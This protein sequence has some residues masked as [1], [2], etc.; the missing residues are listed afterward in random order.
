MQRTVGLQR[1]GLAGLCCGVA[2]MT[3]G[4][5]VWAQ[6]SEAERAARQRQL[7][8]QREQAQQGQQG[9]KEV[10][11]ASD[12]IGMEAKSKEGQQVGRVANLVISSEGQIEYVAIASGAHAQAAPGQ[13]EQ[14]QERQQQQQGQQQVTAGQLTLIP[15]DLVKLQ[16][17]A[18]EAQQFVMLDIEQQQLQR[19][20]SFTLIQLKAPGAHGRW[21]VEVDQFF[22]VR[23]RRGAARPELQQ[24]ER[25]R[26]QEQ[27]QE[28]QKKPE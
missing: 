8:Q 15:W 21:M 22:N 7:Q 13:R 3:A 28:E 4:A 5:A 9:E 19:A 6:Q 20:P 26:Q 10:T 12:L 11:L 23:Q 1:V 27:Q 24:R 18:A 14:Q 2:L 25:Q 16:K 17:G